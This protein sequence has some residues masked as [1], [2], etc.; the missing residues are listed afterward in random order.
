M[1]PPLQAA[2]GQ[3]RHEAEALSGQQAEDLGEAQRAAAP[4]AR[5]PRAATAFLSTI[6]DGEVALGALRG[7][8]EGSLEANAFHY[9]SVISACA[10]SGRWQLGAEIFGE[11]QHKAVPLTS[12]SYGTAVALCTSAAPAALWPTVF[13]LLCGL[14]RVSL[15]LDQICLNAAMHACTE[16]GQWRSTLQLLKI[17][18]PNDITFNSAVNACGSARKWEVGVRFFSRMMVLRLLSERSYGVLVDLCG[19]ST[20]W[21][22]ALQ[23]C[24]SA[25][26]QPN[27][28]TLNAATTACGKA[29][30]WSAA[31]Q[32]LR[33]PDVIGCNA[34][35][36]ACEKSGQ[37]QAA[38][39]LSDLQP[40]ADVVSFSA[41]ISAV[42]Q[43]N[44]W[45]ATVELLDSMLQQQV[46]PNSVI[47]TAAS[48]AFKGQTGQ[49]QKAFWLRSHQTKTGPRERSSPLC[50]LAWRL[51]QPGA[52]PRPVH[53]VA[54][55]FCSSRDS[56]REEMEPFAAFGVPASGCLAIAGLWLPS[57]SCSVSIVAGVALLCSAGSSAT[58]AFILCWERAAWMSSFANFVLLGSESVP[59]IN[60]E[61]WC[62]LVSEEIAR[63]VQQARREPLAELRP[64]ELSVLVWSFASLSV[65]DFAVDRFVNAVEHCG[66]FQ[67]FRTSDLARLSWSLTSLRRASAVL[68]DLQKEFLHRLRCEDVDAEFAVSALTLLWSGSFA[69]WLPKW[70][71]I[72]MEGSLA[73]FGRSCD[74]ALAGAPA[75]APAGALAPIVAARHSAEHP[76]PPR[77]AAG[78]VRGH[79][80]GSREPKEPYLVLSLADL[81]V[82][83]KPPEWQVDDREDSEPHER[84]LLSAYVQALFPRCR[85]LFTH[86]GR[87]RG[88]LHRLDVPSSGLILVAKS[89]EAWYRLKVQA[90]CGG[91]RRDYIALCHGWMGA[92]RQEISARVHW[93]PDGRRGPSH[94]EDAGRLAKTMLKVTELRR[95]AARGFSLVDIRIV[96]GRMH[97]IR[98][99]TAHVGHPT[100]RDGKYTPIAT[101]QEDA[102]WCP[103]HFLHRYSLAFM[104]MSK[105]QHK[106][107]EPLAKSLKE[108]LRP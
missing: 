66:G 4:A 36:S 103:D 92:G 83:Q 82:V 72:E 41:A 89:H 55:A 16:A 105:R 24:R 78:E 51:A 71:A 73:E 70:T 52:R 96:T 30:Q 19:R 59:S 62:S 86:L 101:F 38:L 46:K 9:N 12:S 102:S 56:Q 100:V 76:D 45:P 3:R 84:G 54:R 33:A 2:A 18:M 74:T 10:K 50:E 58:L 68:E 32:L 17:S 65:S 90:A 79:A 29:S 39:H 64:V 42:G 87:S 43:S 28:I 6:Q 98:L 20:A 53:G 80:R 14:R 60:L 108:A 106:V 75:G 95:T 40:A 44:L 1:R 27:P 49:W 91:I 63:L 48:C 99:H 61:A 104:D 15:Q 35:M 69:G 5:A 26:V 85:K 23:L 47:C 34:A 93:W 81:A 25:A 88:F 7:L 67:N 37:W 77:D 8:L 11:L 13:H 31:L 21:R 97:Q 107:F 57:G 22:L 94:V